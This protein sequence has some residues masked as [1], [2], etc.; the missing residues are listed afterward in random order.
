MAKVWAG[1]CRRRV[2]L[3]RLPLGRYEMPLLCWRERTLKETIHGCCALRWRD[4]RKSF[5]G[6]WWGWEEN[7]CTFMNSNSSITFTTKIKNT[8]G[9]TKVERYG[10]NW[11]VR[12]KSLAFSPHL[13][14]TMIHDSSLGPTVSNDRHHRL[15]LRMIFNPN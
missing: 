10:G 5:K 15:Y 1:R 2:R 13:H 14:R 7:Q 9:Y 4:G 3:L 8:K 12:Q 6:R 11:L